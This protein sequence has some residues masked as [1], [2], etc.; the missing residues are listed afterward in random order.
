RP[1]HRMYVTHPLLDSECLIKDLSVH[2]MFGRHRPVH[3]GWLD[4][5]IVH[6]TVQ[7]DSSQ[8][9]FD[10][11]TGPDWYR[12]GEQS[13][14]KSTMSRRDNERY[15]NCR[16]FTSDCRGDRHSRP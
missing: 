10:V 13:P 9:C 16:A 8:C 1:F 5:Q 11:I 15:V 4:E 6:R 2:G 7:R 12:T 14:T 3:I